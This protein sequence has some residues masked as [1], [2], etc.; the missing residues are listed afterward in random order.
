M[1]VQHELVNFGM[2]VRIRKSLADVVF[3]T[4]N[5]KTNASDKLGKF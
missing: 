4:N 2:A 5:L 3:Q 1:A